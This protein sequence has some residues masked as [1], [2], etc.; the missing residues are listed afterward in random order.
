MGSPHVLPSR[1]LMNGLEEFL[2]RYRAVTVRYKAEF[3]RSAAKYIG[4]ETSEAVNLDLLIT[5][6]QKGTP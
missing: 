2:D 6:G 5:F 4:Q 3:I 1:F